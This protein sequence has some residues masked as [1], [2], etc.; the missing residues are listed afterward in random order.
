MAGDSMTQFRIQ[1]RAEYK[2]SLSETKS[3]SARAMLFALLVGFLLTP[4]LSAV[5]NDAQKLPKPLV[6]NTSRATLCPLLPTFHPRIVSL[7]PSNTELLYDIHAENE[8]VGVCSFCDYP[9][10]AKKI[11]RTGT[12]VSANLERMTRLKPSAIL[13]VS[14]QEALQGLL[15]HNGFHVYLLKNIRLTDIGQNIEQLGQITGNTSQA[16]DVDSRFSNALSSLRQIL[17]TTKTQ[18]KV[19]YCVWPQPLLTVGKNSFLDDVVTTC[20]AVNIAGDATAAYPHF[21][22]EKLVLSDPDVIILPYEAH[23]KI[24]LKAAPWSLLRA[25]KQDKVYYLLEPEKNGL[26]RPTTRVISGLYWLCDKVHPEL[27]PEL[28][29][30][31]EKQTN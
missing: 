21:S 29:I 5:A 9:E 1:A 17:S 6:T 27:A 26:L 30:W 18:P 10:A 23:N 19:F 25:V 2:T 28:K 11:E 7:A 12:F 24:D 8:L 22:A 20:G 14:G 13:L 4:Q 31:Y 16:K 3:W 15:E